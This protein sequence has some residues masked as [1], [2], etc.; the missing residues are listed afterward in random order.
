MNR[1]MTDLLVKAFAVACVLASSVDFVLSADDTKIRTRTE[2]WMQWRGPTADG[3][4][5]DKAKPPIQWDKTTNVSWSVDLLGEGSATPIVYGNQI[6][7]LSAVKTDRKS[8]KPVVNDERAKTTPD[9]FFY[10]FVV[11]SYDRNSGKN[12]WQRIVVEDVPHEGKHETHTYAA[13]SPITDGERL[14]FSF[15][16]RGVFC[17]SL[18]GEPIWNLDLGDMRTRNG[19]GEAVT[20]VLADDLVIINWDQEEGSFITAIDKRSGQIRWKKDREG[21]VTSWN[22]PFV[23]SF[24]GQLQI[25]VNGTKSVKSYD[26]K[27]GTVLWE[28]GG[29]T[30]NAIPSPIRFNDSVI[31]MSGYR[32]SLACSIPLTS[33]GDVTNSTKVQWKITQGTPYVPSPILAGTRLLFTAG[34][35]NALSCIDASTGKPL[36]ER[37][38]LNAIG[39][40]YASPILAGGHFYFTSREGTT[41]VV[42]DNESLDIVAV[43]T[44]DDVIDASP[45]AVD[46]Q[47]FLRS[48]KKLYC[49]ENV[50]APEQNGT[51]HKGQEPLPSPLSF[52]SVNLENTSETSANASVGDLNG[53]GYL[54]IVLAK[55]RHWPLHNRILFNDGQGNFEARNLGSQP[56]RSY[57]AVL[58]DID[59]DGDLDIVVS[60]DKP[61]EKVAY[62]NDGKGNFSIDRS[63]GDASWNT[64]NI[65]LA[66]LN[67]DGFLDLIVA[68]RKS[69]SY[70]ILN[71][72]KGTFLKEN[73]IVVPSE[74]ATTIVAADFDR[75]G[76]VD[77]AVPHRDGGTS[78]ILFN[79]DKL[80]F[81]RAIAYGPAKAS[82][83][84]CAAGDFN[85]DGTMDLIAGDDRLGTT[86]Y[87]N[88]G[89][90]NLSTAIQI[91]DSKLAAYSIATGMVNRDDHLDL[92]VGYSSGES[93]VFLN[94]GTGKNFQEL[95]FGDE[96][97]AVYGLTLGD[98]NGDDSLDIVQA[99]SDGPN[100]VIFCSE[101]RSEPIE[102]EIRDV[103]GWQVHIAKKL[104]ETEADDTAK[105]LSG[106]KKMLDEIVRDVPAAAVTEM[107]KVPLYF[108]PSYKEG[109]SGAEFHPGAGWLR[110]NGR[111]PAMAQ[112]VEFSG[113]RDFEA[114]MRRMP[115]FA[116]HELAHAYHFR[117]LPDGFGNEEIK[118]AFNR[119]KENGLYDRVERTFGNG[120]PGTFERA[121]AMTNAMEYFAETSEAYF[122]RNDFF[123]FTREELRRHDPEMYALLEKLWGVPL[124]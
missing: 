40:I 47:M 64:R 30:V 87:I 113:V 59:N 5:G 74:S 115:N 94:D 80:S 119:A 17:Y 29:Q 55:G 50:P 75:D 22:T 118:A 27:Y 15:G 100:A 120:N 104:L 111:D 21:E 28:C 67:G 79:D 81:Q 16:S 66:D 73:T 93:L 65:A 83:R 18:E 41:V 107:K 10:Q 101:S 31:C 35:T 102:R 121:Y 19:W 11:S 12:L 84:A 23:T 62:K 43:N 49:I 7:V 86:L 38:R 2:N 76:F 8:P 42:K 109:Q 97:G 24:K 105:A 46:D 1:F 110:D 58:G 122:F 44:L 61:D 116:L 51:N 77:L 72:G 37:M 53:D 89:K 13:G 114:E 14:Y 124:K 6:F 4:A 103:S 82:T 68:N 25:V 63:W 52:K 98:F 85:G 3:R 108:S 71:N 32:G 91:G 60:N 95:S 123:P 54:D 78:R 33:Q 9:E 57:A 96:T 34:N 45:V 20:P 56:D 117:T 90:G 26:A 48:W 69:S 88:D 99:R 36:L 112:G 39:S 92:I 70:V 106:L